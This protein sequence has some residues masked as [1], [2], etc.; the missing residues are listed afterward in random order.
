MVTLSVGLVTLRVYHHWGSSH[1]SA[2]STDQPVH[3]RVSH[4][5]WGK[6]SPEPAWSS[7]L[8]IIPLADVPESDRRHDDVE[9]QKGYENWA[10]RLPMSHRCDRTFEP[11]TPA[12]R[13]LGVALSDCW[14]RH[15]ATKF[16]PKS[17]H[18]QFGF[19]IYSGWLVMLITV[20]SGARTKNLR[21]PHASFVSG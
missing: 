6:G 4:L 14:R 21:R 18:G 2:L 7:D 16:G 5:E 1:D 13:G 8:R 9:D 12:G 19:Q 15:E 10:A 11:P 3:R 20:P 17:E